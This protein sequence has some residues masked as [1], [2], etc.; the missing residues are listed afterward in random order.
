M[1]RFAKNLALFF[2]VTFLGCLHAKAQN[3]GPWLGV[4]S[5]NVTYTISGTG[6]GPDQAGYVWTTSHQ[7]N[8]NSVLTSPQTK[9]AAQLSWTGQA[10]GTGSINDIGV[11][12]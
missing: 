12:S 4:T 2:A 11:Q 5:W 10:D 1:K 9:C 3:C 6:S 7:V 8:G